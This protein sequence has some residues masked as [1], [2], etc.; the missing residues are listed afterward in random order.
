MTADDESRSM[1]ERAWRRLAPRRVHGIAAVLLPFQA[2]GRVDWEGFERQVVRT[3]AA[4][5]DCAVNMDT[6]FGDLLT[7]AERCAVLDATRRALGPGPG[8]YAGAYAESSDDPA[9]AYARSTAE[10]ERRGATPVIV[11]CRAMHAMD[12]ATRAALYARIAHATAAGAIGFELSP[13]FAPHGAIWDDE[14][15]ARLLE[16]PELLGA[17]HS[18]LD[19][20]RELA[21]LAVR[22]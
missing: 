4:G 7:F 14:T 2:A 8:F 15:F 11:Q 16:I 12:A 3:H 5:L 18:S 13:R 6:G 20:G 22:D 17:K 19:R 9:P 10:I 1:L 21:R